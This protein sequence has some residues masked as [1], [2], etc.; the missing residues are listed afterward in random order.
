MTV[1]VLPFS[2]LA[3]KGSKK[4]AVNLMSAI[5]GVSCILYG[6]TSHP[7]LI[8]LGCFMVGVGNASYAP[9]S[10]SILTSWT[11]RFRWGSVIGAYNS[12][13]PVF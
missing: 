7:F 10:V 3:D 9:V 12:A 11:R 2:L 13:L 5:W 8:V 4:H 1:F 6:L